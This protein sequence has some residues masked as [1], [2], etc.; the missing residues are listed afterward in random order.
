M[1]ALVFFLHAVPTHRSVTA[2]V[3]CESGRPRLSSVSR[4][5][6]GDSTGFIVFLDQL[7]SSGIKNVTVTLWEADV[8]Q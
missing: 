1:A 6:N 3:A 2:V 8:Q 5:N 4:L 7:I